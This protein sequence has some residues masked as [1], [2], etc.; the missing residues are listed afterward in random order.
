MSYLRT[1]WR[2]QTTSKQVLWCSDPPRVHT[3]C[4]VRC[5]RAVNLKCHLGMTLRLQPRARLT[6]FY[7]DLCYVVQCAVM[8]LGCMASQNC[9][10][11]LSMALMPR[12]AFQNRVLAPSNHLGTLTFLPMAA[13]TLSSRLTDLYHSPF[14]FI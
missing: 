12:L 7:C 8:R 6:D 13:L 5:I 1:Q 14:R 4:I 3:L 9:N 11:S 2:V 10:A